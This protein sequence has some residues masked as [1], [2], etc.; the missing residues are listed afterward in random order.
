MAGARLS[1]CSL[2][3]NTCVGTC[4]YACACVCIQ[5]LRLCG[6]KLLATRYP[7]PPLC[8]QMARL[9]GG[10]AGF[11]TAQAARRRWL[12]PLLR[13]DD[14]RTACG[15]KR[16]DETRI[17]RPNHT[18]LFAGRGLALGISRGGASWTE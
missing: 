12:V 15:W 6:S 16:R 5:Y 1:G 11:G 14:A 4:R 8:V 13:S 10:E 18:R 9:I 3:V 17:A 2:C 7:V